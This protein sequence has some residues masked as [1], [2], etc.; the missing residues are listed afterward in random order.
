MLIL[1]V[2]TLTYTFFYIPY[3]HYILFITYKHCIHFTLDLPGKQPTPRPESIV[4][5]V[6]SAN[7]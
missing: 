5:P 4:Q 2:I 1:E 7:T 3:L 6:L